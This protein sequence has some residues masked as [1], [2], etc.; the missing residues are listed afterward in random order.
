MDNEEPLT[1]HVRPPTNAVLTVRIIKSFPYRNVKNQILPSVDLK[2]TNPAQLF[3]MIE[4]LIATT[5]GLRPYRTVEYNTLKVYTHAHGSKSMNLVINFEG[6]SD[7]DFMIF[8]KDPSN[9]KSGT[10]KCL[11]D[12]GIENETELSIFNWEGYQDFKKNPEEK[13]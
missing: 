5:G 1:S 8:C 10:E 4:K 12:L 6:D 11:W 2:N 7:D 13:W 3:E 9:T